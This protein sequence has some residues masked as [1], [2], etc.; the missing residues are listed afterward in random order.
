MA[1]EDRSVSLPRGFSTSEQCCGPIPFHYAYSNSRTHGFIFHRSHTPTLD[2]DRLTD[3][4]V[5][6]LHLLPGCSEAASVFSPTIKPR[7][8]TARLK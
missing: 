6:L 7:E 4:S 3:F 2:R 8:E 1:A 5:Q